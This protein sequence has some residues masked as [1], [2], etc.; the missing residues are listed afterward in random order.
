M[1]NFTVQEEYKLL[2]EWEGVADDRSAGGVVFRPYMRDGQQRYLVALIRRANNWGWDLPKGHPEDHETLR[3]AAIREVYEE[4]GLKAE[5][6]SE[7]GEARYLNGAKRGPIRKAV[8]YYLMR[9]VSSPF[10]AP[11]ADPRPQPGETQDAAWCD[12]EGAIALVLFNN[13]RAILQR[14]KNR[15]YKLDDFSETGVEQ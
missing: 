3:E 1:T 2:N 10:E 7:L 8:T 5:V 9:D 4:T 6:I 13:S 14:A 15:L 11:P 12:L